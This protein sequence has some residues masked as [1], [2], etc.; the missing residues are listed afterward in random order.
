M[1]EKQEYANN[2]KKTSYKETCT[3][4]R[5]EQEEP[6]QTVKRRKLNVLEWLESD[7]EDEE[8]NYSI[9]S[10]EQAKEKSAFHETPEHILTE[11]EMEVQV[12]DDAFI[13]LKKRL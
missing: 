11:D 3:S 7:F 12:E 1:E 5:K 4:K 8:R 10:D 13:F 9:S 6:K 2:D